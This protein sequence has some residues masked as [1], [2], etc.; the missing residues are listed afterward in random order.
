MSV[1]HSNMTGRK[2]RPDAPRH[3]R[4]GPRHL[5]RQRRP[6]SNSSHDTFSPPVPSLAS[7]PRPPL[8][9]PCP[10]FSPSPPVSLPFSLPLSLE[11]PSRHKRHRPD[12][13]LPHLPSH[14]NHHARPLLMTSVRHV[15]HGNIRAQGRTGYPRCHHTYCLSTLAI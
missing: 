8:Q 14:L 13:R 5:T 6:R 9:T 1:N 10:P 11:I 7:L 3:D 2:M 15:P 4:R 12:H